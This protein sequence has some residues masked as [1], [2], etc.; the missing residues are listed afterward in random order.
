M[1][2][3]HEGMD[4]D[5]D[6]AGGKTP[7]SEEGADMFQVSHKL[8]FFASASVHTWLLPLY[9]PNAATISVSDAGQPATRS[10]PSL[11]AVEDIHNMDLPYLRRGDRSP[12][13]PEQVFAE[14]LEI[15][16]EEMAHLNAVRTQLNQASDSLYR[17]ILVLCNL[18]GNVIPIPRP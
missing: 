9:Q 1:C 14:A 10:T 6:Q 11:Q 12:R 5:N 2:Q 3:R 17:T 4:I 18:K 15:L 8:I 13:T 16:E 7:E